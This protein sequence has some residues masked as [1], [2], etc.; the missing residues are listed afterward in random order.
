MIKRFLQGVTL[1]MLFSFIFT[2]CQIQINS[3]T[4]Q[5]SVIF[6]IPTYFENKE[7]PIICYK[8]NKSIP[9]NRTVLNYNK[10]VTELG[11]K[12]IISDS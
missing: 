5:V 7:S 2:V 9:K 10:L 4:Y 1:N 12:F 3:L 8:Y 11:N 6:F